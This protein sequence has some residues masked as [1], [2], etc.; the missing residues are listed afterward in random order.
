[1]S[2][3]LGLWMGTL[4][5][6]SIERIKGL[7]KLRSRAFPLHLGK[8]LVHGRLESI[9]HQS[10]RR[11]LDTRSPRH[12][13]FALGGIAGCCVEDDE[14][15]QACESG[16]HITFLHMARSLHVSIC[17]RLNHIRG[18]NMR[19]PCSLTPSLSAAGMLFHTHA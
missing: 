17:S 18:T 2:G 16:M 6:I 14:N 11:R 1:M 5:C 13:E 19:R 9:L 12:V 4:D 3:R 8:L 15:Q 10:P 7:H